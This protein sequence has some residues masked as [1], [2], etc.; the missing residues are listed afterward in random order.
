MGTRHR[1]S[2]A[3]TAGAAHKRGGV[4]RGVVC[5][6]RRRSP[7][8]AMALVRVVPDARRRK[9][10]HPQCVPRCSLC[11]ELM[12]MPPLEGLQGE[13][14]RGCASDE[15]RTPLG[16]AGCTCGA[17]GRPR[18]GCETDPSLP[19]CRACASKLCPTCSPPDAV[20]ACEQCTGCEAR[21]CTPP[22]PPR[23]D[24]RKVRM[25]AT[26]AAMLPE[27]DRS[28]IA[29]KLRYASSSAEVV[30]RGVVAEANTPNGD[31]AIRFINA[32][33][34]RHRRKK[35]RE[36]ATLR[37]ADNAEWLTTTMY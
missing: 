12:L 6:S 33:W 35:A 30:K 14:C 5:T 15:L 8:L 18:F 4:P 25:A 11:A 17:G 13:L 16:V 24:V 1:A 31:E 29:E 27:L 9:P 22:P 10:L 28:L 2:A 3:R 32:A 20:G 23:V 37:K 7:S 34:D 26:K 19:H 21:V 36:R